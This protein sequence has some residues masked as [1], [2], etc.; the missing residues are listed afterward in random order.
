MNLTLQSFLDFFR[1][2]RG[3]L[4]C[5]VVVLLVVPCIAGYIIVLRRRLVSGLPG[6][7]GSPDLA[8]LVAESLKLLLYPSVAPSDAQRFIFWLAPMS[9]LVASFVSLGVFY[10]GPAF[11]IARDIDI[12]VLFVVGVA[13]LAFL[14]TMLYRRRRVL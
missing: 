3:E 4:V 11:R 9:P 8:R 14:G 10:R 2:W 6:Q 13:S 5:A 12:G 7:L 1:T